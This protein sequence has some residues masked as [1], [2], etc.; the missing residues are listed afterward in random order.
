MRHHHHL[1]VGTAT[2]R[3]SCTS[4]RRN[5]R[6]QCTPP[7]R[8]HEATPKAEEDTE[9]IPGHVTSRPQGPSVVLMRATATRPKRRPTVQHQH[10]SVKVRCPPPRSWGTCPS[11]LTPASRET[12][13]VAQKRVTLIAWNDRAATHQWPQPHDTAAAKT[14]GRHQWHP[15]IP[16][17]TGPK[18]PRAVLI[19]QCPT[20]RAATTNA[21]HSAQPP[22]QSGGANATPLNHPPPGCNAQASCTSARRRSRETTNRRQR[23]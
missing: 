9:G 23:R 10:N 5:L 7:P 15:P 12:P 14:I 6:H 21:H 11:L 18:G 17:S 16:P 2:A 22:P 20:V 1:R 3:A 19:A 4:A 13:C 8:R